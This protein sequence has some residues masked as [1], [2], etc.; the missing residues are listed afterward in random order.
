MGTSSQTQRSAALALTQLLVEHPEL[1][2]TA[3][4]VDRDGLL[5]GTVAIHA[6]SDDLHAAMYAYASVL[7]GTV[8]EQR[9]TS[10]E[11]GPSV[12]VSLYATWRDVH[13]NVWGTCAVTAGTTV[14]A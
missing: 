9:F 5:S 3:W 12:S 6:D 8:H 10:P 13:V 1:P 7:G 4:R 11:H 14:A 2:V